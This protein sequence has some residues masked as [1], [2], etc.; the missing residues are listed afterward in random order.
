MSRDGSK[1]CRENPL[2]NEKK[3][4][5]TIVSSMRPYGAAY[6]RSVDASSRHKKKKIRGRTVLKSAYLDMIGAGTFGSFNVPSICS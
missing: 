4:C 6:V 1:V 2:I 5:F 3:K